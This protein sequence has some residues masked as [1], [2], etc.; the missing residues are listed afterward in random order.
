V[1]LRW[2][3]MAL[4]PMGARIHDGGLILSRGAALSPF[5]LVQ[6]CSL[7]MKFDGVSQGAGSDLYSKG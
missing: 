7:A 5:L 1:P 2:L 3:H 4:V 6:R